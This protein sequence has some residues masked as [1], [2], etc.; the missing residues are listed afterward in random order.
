MERSKK[1]WR[2]QFISLKH[3]FIN[4]NEQSKNRGKSNLLLLLFLSQNHFLKFSQQKSYV[5]TIIVVI[6]L[7]FHIKTAPL[8]FD[9]VFVFFADLYSAGLFLFIG[10]KFCFDFFARLSAHAFCK[11]QNQASSSFSSICSRSVFSS[12]VRL[13]LFSFSTFLMV[14]LRLYS[15]DCSRSLACSALCFSLAPI[16]S[17][18]LFI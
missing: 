17:M 6:L 4:K 10:I 14:S 13:R 3:Q 12:P 7:G 15:S 11:K 16:S 2:S 9:L 8:R 1:S 18:I 5:L